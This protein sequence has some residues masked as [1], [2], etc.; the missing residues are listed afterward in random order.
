[1][2]KVFFIF[3]LRISNKFMVPKL[4]KYFVFKKQKTL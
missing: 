4:P 3:Y 2:L 1:M